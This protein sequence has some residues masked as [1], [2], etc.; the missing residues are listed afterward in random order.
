MSIASLIN[1]PHA[2]YDI[3]Q[4]SAAPLTFIAYVTSKYPAPADRK[5]EPLNME[6]KPLPEVLRLI[7][8]HVEASDRAVSSVVGLF[9]SDLARRAAKRGLSV[10]Q[11]DRG[12]Q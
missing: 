7:A 8:A 12:E 3:K 2:V 1:S 11:G 6:S 5:T 9:P 4:A 10:I